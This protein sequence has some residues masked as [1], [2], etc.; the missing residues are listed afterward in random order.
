[1]S[2]HTASIATRYSRMI[3]FRT[4]FKKAWCFGLKVLAL[5]MFCILCCVVQA[6][7]MCDIIAATNIQSQKSQWSCTTLGATSTTPCTAPWSGLTCTGST[8]VKINLNNFGLT[9]NSINTV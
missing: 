7:P 8:V 1:M 3:Y 9:G 4:Y 5:W 6:D 2:V